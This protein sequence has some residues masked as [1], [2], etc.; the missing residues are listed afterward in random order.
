MGS[1]SSTS[2]LATDLE[3]PAA[4]EEEEG[5]ALGG[6]MPAEGTDALKFHSQL[7]LKLPEALPRRAAEPVGVKHCNTRSARDAA[8]A[9]RSPPA[10]APAQPAARGALHQALQRYKLEA[11]CCAAIDR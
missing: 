6:A 4:P 10:R 7:A 9:V 3:A 5:H 1:S 2:V 8:A 11:C